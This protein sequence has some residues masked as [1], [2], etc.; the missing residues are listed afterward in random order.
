MGNPSRY[1]N[2]HKIMILLRGSV[3]VG[4]KKEAQPATD[5]RPMIE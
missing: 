5:K 3:R 4:D 2:K 1:K